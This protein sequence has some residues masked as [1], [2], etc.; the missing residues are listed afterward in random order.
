MIFV[1]FFMPLAIVLGL[2]AYLML[3]WTDRLF[4]HW[5][6]GDLEMRSKLVFSSVQDD[7]TDVFSSR[8]GRLEKQFTQL[9][10]DERLIGIGY[11][12]G[13]GTPVYRNKDFPAGLPCPDVAHISKP[14]FREQTI[15]GG[16]V[17]VATFPVT[18]SI[19]GSAKKGA[20]VIVHDMS[21]AEHRSEQT[22]HYFLWFVFGVSVVAALI[23]MIVARITLSRWVLSL[24]NYVRTGKETPGL[25]REALTIS[26]EIQHRMRQIEREQQRTIS[27]GPT[28]SA[29]M[30]HE[31][32]RNH[33][34]SE[35][36]ITISYR[37]PYAHRSTDGGTA[38]S[39]PASGLVTAIEPIMKA[40][41]GTW[42]AVATSEADRTVADQN[43]ALMVPPDAPSYRLKRLWLSEAEEAGF[44][45]GFANEGIWP[46]CNMAY[47]KP[48]FRASDW[49]MYRA[50]NEKFVNA[51][52]SE[53]KSSAP[54]IFIQDYHFGLLPKLIREKLP[55]ALI[56]VFW[57]IPWPN[58]ETFGILP[59]RSEFLDGLLAADIVGFHTQFLCNNFL[60]SVD[61]HIE[62]LIDREHNTVR[63]GNDFC[64]VRPYPISIAWPNFE[65][66]NIPDIASCRTEFATAL[67]IDPGSKIILGVE[68]LDYIKGIPERLRAFDTFLERNPD[69]RGKIHFVQIASPSRSIIRAY[70]DV[71]KEIEEIVANVNRRFGTSTWQ[72]IHLLKK[73]FSQPE[74]YK[75]YRA[76]DVC[77][78]SSLHEGMNLVAKEFVAARDD[79]RGVLILSQF[80]GSSR[81]LVDALIINPYDDESLSQCL[82]RAL[83]MNE[84]EQRARMESMREHV[85]SHNIFAWAAEILGD[86]SR[87]HHRRQLNGL[88]NQMHKPKKDAKVDMNAGENV[89]A[90]PHAASKPG[91]KG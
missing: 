15:R 64:M 38:W 47:I 33:L 5:S 25:P 37:Q 26:R 8:A 43:G 77:I 65:T 83:N 41:Q 4:L 53:A 66:M 35:Q 17:M 2:L 59:W 62:A 51:V 84:D 22:R 68:R 9:A 31:F 52:L 78:I 54:I 88:L 70:A 89:L 91:R 6:E 27:L 67:G 61:T 49:E 28:W 63:H 72:P 1:R 32:V 50:V 34:P 30:L 73:N 12:S 71:D 7:L 11:C 85:K 16:E 39:T 60:D 3:P 13:S 56:I 45:A 42:I 10:K 44:Y 82:L 48:R 74:V 81:E 90:W 58:S 20:L 24:R 23:T 55:D 79:G 40:C 87:L 75:F 36:L 86:A 57:H 69:R 76:A 80:A 29:T 46:L 18:E 14:Q 21:F 19:H